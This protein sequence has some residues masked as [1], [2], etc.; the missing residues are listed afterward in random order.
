MEEALQLATQTAERESKVNRSKRYVHVGLHVYVCMAF[1]SLISEDVFCYGLI[2]GGSVWSQELDSMTLMGPF[3]L[4]MFHGSVIFTCLICAGK[5]GDWE[6]A[7]MC[8][9]HCGHE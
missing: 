9:C 1:I 3:Q 2:L 8:I 5:Q 4:R 7:K 6:D